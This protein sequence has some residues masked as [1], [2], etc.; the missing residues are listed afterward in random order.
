MSATADPHRHFVHWEDL[1]IGKVVPFGH[2]L[3]T[4]E[5][6]V[7]FASA[8]DPQRI[9]LDEEFARTSIVG[10]LCASGFHSCCMLMR[11]YADDVL[12]R[13]ASLGAPGIE[14]AKW[15]K[16]VRPGDV[17]SARYTVKAKRVM[18]S[19]PDVG[20][21][22][23]FTEMLNQHGDL[24]M[25]WD[26]HQFSRLRDPSAARQVAAGERP[27]EAMLAKPV[28]F[29]DGP[30][31]PPPSR[32]GNFFEDRVVGE[33]DDIGS[34]TFTKE[35]II[36]FARAWDPQPFHLDEAAAKASLFGGLAAS[37]WHT[38][39]I[40]IRQSV[41]ARRIIE[42]AIAAKGERL[43]VYGPSP[44]FKNLRWIKP[45]MAGD[46][47]EFRNRTANKID[48]KSRPDRGLMIFDTQ[49]RNQKGEIVFAI[50]GQML[51]ERRE[52]FKVG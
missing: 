52:A 26:S 35:S 51:V 15:M 37:G 31:G 48:L 20:I 47:I 22:H 17:L 33:M 34:Y 11:M 23:M 19:R 4:K 43:A 21:A 18:S 2:R 42:A 5:D 36:A 41:A 44:G 13:A 39:A 29:W 28:S 3:V 16:P 8:Y 32:E 50:T 1:E 49:G 38:A 9:H 12:N 25:S 40:Y 46:T 10:G 27:R 7:S 30:M 45:V 24:L 14:E 6:I